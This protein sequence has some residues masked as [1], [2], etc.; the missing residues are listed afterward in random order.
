MRPSIPLMC[1]RSVHPSGGEQIVFIW[2]HTQREM[3]YESLLTIGP[4]VLLLY[5]NGG[6]GGEATSYRQ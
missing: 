4:F 6:G 5:F 2:P 1:L 3:K